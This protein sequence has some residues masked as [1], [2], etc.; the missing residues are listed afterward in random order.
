MDASATNLTIR[1]LVAAGPVVGL[2]GG[3][4]YGR[5]D[6][7]P[8]GERFSLRIADSTL[9]LLAASEG[10]EDLLSPARL[11]GRVSATLDAESVARVRALV[12]SLAPGRDDVG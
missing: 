9:R 10:F 2:Y 6:G 12:R 3:A 4:G 7:E 1:H 11:T 5:P 8:G